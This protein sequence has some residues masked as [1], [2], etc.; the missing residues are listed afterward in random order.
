LITAQTRKKYCRMQSE[1]EQEIRQ[2]AEGIDQTEPEPEY[3]EDA[4]PVQQAPEEQPPAQIPLSI[5]TM[6]ALY[7][8][9]KGKVIDPDTAILASLGEHYVL[10]IRQWM[11][12]FAW[13][14]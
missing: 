11:R 7:A 8:Q 10:T 13:G 4:L 12:L 9:M 3:K 6:N 1:V 2:Q 5:D 14:S